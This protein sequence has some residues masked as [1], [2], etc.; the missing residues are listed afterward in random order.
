MGRVFRA[1]DTPPGPHRGPEGPPARAG[2]RP[3]HPAALP[4]RGPIGGPARPRQHRPGL[5]RGRG[6]RPALHRVRVRRGGERPAAG[7]AAGTACRWPRRSAT[8]LQVA[9]AL[10]HA[11]SRSVVHRDIKPSNVL[12]TPEGQ[13]KL[14]DMGLAR[15]RETDPAAADLTASGVTLGTFDYISP[16]QARDPRNA[17]VRSDIYSLGCTLFFML[18]G[19]PPFPGRD[20][21]AEAARS[22]R[23]TSRPTSASFGPELPEDVPR[24]LRKMMAKDP[25]HRYR[26]PAELVDELL[27]L[28]KS[29]GLRRPAG[30]G[31]RAR[32]ARPRSPSGIVICR[33]SSRWWPCW[34]SCWCCTRYGP[35]PRARDAQG[36][37]GPPSGPKARLPN[38]LL[39]RTPSGRKTAMIQGATGLE[40]AGRTRRGRRAG[41]RRAPR[42]AWSRHRVGHFSQARR[43][44]LAALTTPLRPARRLCFSTSFAANRF[45]VMLKHHLPQWSRAISSVG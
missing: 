17:D 21:A 2:G 14:I 3:R 35:I 25:R 42:T 23:A 19:Q 37:P 30:A 38:G 22:T 12:I 26:T 43:G 45:S 31:P 29:A 1:L 8:R 4:E 20:G 40:E 36:H 7:R 27:A 33:G 16:E 5:L 18:A 13:V 9:D 11:A 6:P 39:R 41:P 34:R 32:R 15:F 24:I 44:R 10:A 28:V